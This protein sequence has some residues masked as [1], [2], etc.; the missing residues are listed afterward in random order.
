MCAHA[1][2]DT[3]RCVHVVPEIMRVPLETGRSLNHPEISILMVTSVDPLEP[4]SKRAIERVDCRKS[5]TIDGMGTVMTGGHRHRGRGGET[6]LEIY[7]EKRVIRRFVTSVFTEVGDL[8][9]FTRVCH[10]SVSSY[11]ARDRTG[12]TRIVQLR[13]TQTLRFPRSRRSMNGTT[14]CWIRT[15]APGKF[16]RDAPAP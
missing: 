13:F 11:V 10:E 1:G 14:I 2:I 9:C 16:F 7:A 3:C 12:F 8:G 6:K 4:S 5:R 15:V